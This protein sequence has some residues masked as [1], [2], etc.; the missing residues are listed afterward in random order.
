MRASLHILRPVGSIIDV[1][2]LDFASNLMTCFVDSDIDTRTGITDH[3]DD[4]QLMHLRYL[5]PNNGNLC[6]TDSLV[7]FWTG[8]TYSDL[9]NT[10]PE[11]RS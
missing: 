11:C 9:C 1:G 6:N 7:G 2:G 8:R 3:V 10:I 4:M 5:A